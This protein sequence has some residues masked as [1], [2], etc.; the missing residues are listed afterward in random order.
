MSGSLVAGAAL[1]GLVDVP[2][3]IG[4]A[5]AAFGGGVLIA[6]VGLEVVPE[7]EELTGRAG[8]TAGIV[9]GALIFIGADWLLTREESQREFRR[10]MHAS[11]ARRLERSSGGTAR[12]ESIALGIFIDGVPETAALGITIADGKIGMALL[13]GIVFSNLSESYGAS[14]FMIHGGRSRPAAVALFAGIGAAL[15]AALVVGAEALDAVPDGPIGIGVAVA[16]GAVLATVSI[17]IIPNAFL[18]VSRFAAFAIV[19]GFVAGY[20]LR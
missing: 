18:E 6:A 19:L 13:A 16:A 4:A 9:A 7:A 15:L 12:G 20:L 14:A 3:E 1:A 11:A 10:K 5:V 2:D 17:S 8:T